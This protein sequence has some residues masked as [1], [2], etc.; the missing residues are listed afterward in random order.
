MW[1]PL[2][3]FL[4]DSG[5]CPP[6][7]RGCGHT[8]PSV[9]NALPL[10]FCLGTRFISQDPAPAPHPLRS[11]SL[12]LPPTHPCRLDHV[13]LLSHYSLH[14]SV[15]QNP[16]HFML[17]FIFMPLYSIKRS[18]FSDQTVSSSYSHSLDW[19]LVISRCSTSICFMNGW[20]DK[21]MKVWIPPRT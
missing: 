18:A 5:A 2:C 16:W 10:P 21:G 12:S 19:G 20:M 13:V 15:F 11:L 7:L 3:L 1:P 9:W 8:A 4:G 14:K 6:R 17:V